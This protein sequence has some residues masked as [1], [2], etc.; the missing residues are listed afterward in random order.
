[1]RTVS[2]WTK[3]ITSSSRISASCSDLLKVP[4]DIQADALVDPTCFRVHIKI[5]PFHVGCVTYVSRGNSSICTVAAIGNF[6]ALRGPSP[7]LSFCFADC[8]PLTQ[9]RLS[10]MVPS[11]LHSAG[12]QGS[13]SGHSFL[14]GVATTAAAQGVPDHLIKT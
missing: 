7:G 4:S 10:S 14:I 5:D 9:Q 13:Y 1:M 6:L 12:H 3:L 8:H 11:I 2:F